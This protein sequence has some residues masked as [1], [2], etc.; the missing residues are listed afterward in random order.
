MTCLPPSS[1]HRPGVSSV[2]ESTEQGIGEGTS[3]H[4]SR[5]HDYLP[6]LRCE[7]TLCGVIATKFETQV[8]DAI[9][10]VTDQ[11]CPI[12]SREFARWEHMSE[13]MQVELGSESSVKLPGVVKHPG[14]LRIERRKRARST[15]ILRA[16]LPRDGASVSLELVT[17][18]L[19][20]VVGRMDSWGTL[21]KLN[22]FSY[23][24]CAEPSVYSNLPQDTRSR[25]DV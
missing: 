19:L 14:S 3:I 2:L 21:R 22:I 11:T 9:S 5:V 18:H 8:S 24:H 23:E 6:Q 17:F 4:T 7:N 13:N 12:F 25:V 1:G 16:K 10:N 15:G 20:G